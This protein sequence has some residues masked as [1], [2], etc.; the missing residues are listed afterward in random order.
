MKALLRWLVNW[1]ANTQCEDALWTRVGTHQCSRARGHFGLHFEDH[2]HFIK[3][4]FYW[5][6]YS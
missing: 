5:G 4:G 6:Y 2:S 1:A 3:T